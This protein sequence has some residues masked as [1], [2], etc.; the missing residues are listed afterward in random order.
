[1]KRNTLLL[2][3]CIIVIVLIVLLTLT[4]RATSQENNNQKIGVILPLSGQ[5]A[6]IGNDLLDGINLYKEE[7]PKKVIIVEDDGLESKKSI[8]AYRKLR[9][10][11]KVSI[12]VGPVGPVTTNSIGGSMSTQDKEESMIIGLTLCTDEFD[13][14]LNIYCTYPSLKF[15]VEEAAKTIK[16]YGDTS[17][18]LTENS[19]MGILLGDYAEDYFEQYGINLLGQDKFMPNEELFYTIVT[20]AIETDPDA[21]YIVSATPYSNLKIASSLREQGY[22]GKIVIGSDVTE[23]YLADFGKI[24]DG[25]LFVG[26]IEENYL[27]GFVESFK[28]K[29]GKNPNMYHALGYEL[30]AAGFKAQEERISSDAFPVIEKNYD[31]AIKNLQYE[32]RQVRIPMVV[33]QAVDAKLVKI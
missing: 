15:Q 10:V 20:K 9:D 30:V 3:S 25:V 14:Y 21:V 12:I 13:A 23:K 17:Y 16:K 33:K 28:K 18:I 24:L 7:N 8:S 19:E 26:Q 31:F 27:P 6:E 32:G 4:L 1:M 11:D 5:F 22:K 2:G 29:Y